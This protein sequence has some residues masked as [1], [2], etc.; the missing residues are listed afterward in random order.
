MAEEES[1]LSRATRLVIKCQWQTQELKLKRTKMPDVEKRDE[2]GNVVIENNKPV[3]V[4]HS[5]SRKRL[6]RKC[7]FPNAEA[8]KDVVDFLSSDECLGY[9]KFCRKELNKAIGEGVDSTIDWAPVQAWYTEEDATGGH[10]RRGMLYHVLKERSDDELGDGPY[11]TTDGCK[12]VEEYTF[13]WDVDEPPE[14][15]KSTS[16]VQYS[17]DIKRRDDAEALGGL[18]DC[19]LV[20]RTTLQQDVAAYESHH[21]LGEARVTAQML[22]VSDESVYD[23]EGRVDEETLL[24]ID[25]KI[26]KF[27]AEQGLQLEDGPVYEKKEDG[28]DDF[29][30]PT[31]VV[32]DISKEK[33]AD[34]TT[35]VTIQNTKEE[36]NH[37]STVIGEQTIRAKKLTVVDENVAP[38]TGE[39]GDTYPLT[40]V[41]DGRVVRKTVTKTKGG[42]RVIQ[43]ETTEALE[44]KD[45]KGTVSCEKTI[46]E[47]QHTSVAEGQASATTDATK[48]GSGKTYRVQSTLRDDGKFDVQSTETEELSVDD[49]VEH[50]AENGMSHTVD[51]TKKNQKSSEFTTDPAS[52]AEAGD[53]GYQVNNKLTDTQV[54][55]TP[56][57]A[58]DVRTVTRTPK[59]VVKNLVFAQN[60]TARRTTQLHVKIFENCQLTDIGF[61][62]DAGDDAET[63]TQAT[64][65]D[66]S[67]RLNEYGLYDGQLQYYKDASDD[68]PDTEPKEAWAYGERT[69]T[70][71]TQFA[72]NV[73]Q[74]TETWVEAMGYIEEADPQK[75]YSKFPKAQDIQVSPANRERTQ[76]SVRVES[77]HYFVYTSIINSA[78]HTVGTPNVATEYD[79]AGH[80]TS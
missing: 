70:G 59:K 12:Y 9:L 66:G 74:Y 34:C 31:G 47:H 73:W 40:E 80:A 16:G 45:G 75:I 19:T 58:Y 53:K 54:T 79:E 60:V 36:K 77:P 62:A 55:R 23:E 76:W 50:V 20:K 28:S 4:E 65:T 30:K 51:V 21:E 24:N 33:N 49:Y 61:T 13:F 25:E 46:F 8:A 3:M 32:V 48:A 57:G 68:E 7:E 44:V 10:A 41:K 78:T 56:G 2:D 64:Y 11:V 29:T 39:D 5:V 63:Y 6:V 71:I 43:T 69:K 22:G 35:S 42:V 14:L 18:Y 67:I 27:A 37:R 38:E 72:D 52:P 15:P 17:L 1:R 26:A